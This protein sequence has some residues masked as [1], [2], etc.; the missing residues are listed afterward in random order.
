MSTRSVLECGGKSDATPLSHAEWFSNSSKASFA[1]KHCRRCAV[2]APSKT[3]RRLAA[4]MVFMVA[5]SSAHTQSYSIDWFT[6]DGGGGASVG[7][8]YSIR[9]TIGQPDAGGP[10][11]G[12]AFAVTGGFWV[13]PIGVP[14]LEMPTLM[15]VP[16]G[17]GQAR[18]LWMPNTPGYVLQQS[19]SLSPANWMDAPSGAANPVTVPAT[20][21]V[22]FYRLRKP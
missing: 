10:M 17:P 20:L 3:G 21:P 5:A 1:R 22:K 13:L 4:L 19:S 18:I 6:I 7:G 15:I 9:G 8:G 2:P 14:M 12:G 11:T 16:F